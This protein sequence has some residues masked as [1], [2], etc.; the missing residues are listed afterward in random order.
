MD[1]MEEKISEILGN[2][3]MMQQIMAMAQ[4]L[5]SNQETRTTHQ[6]TSESSTPVSSIDPAF[7]AKLSGLAGSTSID[8]DQRALL[9]AL[10]PYLSQER[11]VRLEKAMQAARIARI[12]SVFLNQNGL[13]F[14]TGR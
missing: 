14:F 9:I 7:I 11:V 3:K 1:E 4:S 13:S 10:K 2:P 12:A 8:Q 5:G 6:D